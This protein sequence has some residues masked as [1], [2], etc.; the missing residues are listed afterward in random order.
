MKLALKLTVAVMLV[1]AILLLIHG[2]LVVEREVELFEED[3]ERHAKIVGNAILAMAPEFLQQGG[4][5]K[6]GDIIE[7]VN[8]VE[9][10]LHIRLVDIREASRDFLKL[11]ISE[12]DLSKMRDGHRVMNRAS[13]EDDHEYLYAYFPIGIENFDHYAIEIAESLVPMQQYIRNTILRKIVLFIAVVIMGSFLV[14]WLGA[15]M[16]GV[17]V[18]NMVQSTIRVS[19]GDF[20][21]AVIIKN[22][23]DELSKLA[24]GLN[25]MITHLRISRERLNEE[26]SQKMK[27]L[28][29]LHHAERLA[30][31]G[32]LASGLAHELGTPLNVVS[33]RAKM[34]SSGQLNSE[35][36]S[37]CARI[38]DDQSE[39]MTKI[40]RQL[41]DFARQQSP[42][43]EP[44][45][46]SK[47]VGK[48]LSLLGPLASN[49]KIEFKLI[50]PKH[51][52]VINIDPGQIQQVLTNL[53]MN[54]IHAMP[55]GGEIK[56]DIKEAKTQ[57]PADL[58]NQVDNYACV[59]IIDNG[60]GIPAEILSQ[61]FTPF[62]STKDV[63][64]GTGLG[65]SI[66]HGIVREHKGW[67][68]VSSEE[69]KGSIFSVY[70]PLED[71]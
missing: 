40:I 22:K 1:I 13:S 28:E 9:P 2:F 55:D 24:A 34:V 38:I 12:S 66:S 52:L 15:K 46:I 32:K 36:I 3:M 54:A 64:K 65:L 43:K 10:F 59:E 8:A 6:L 45:V 68:A 19:D 50:R 47:L 51:Q 26:T 69:G 58:G 4:E 5:E 53:T 60:V 63:G 23:N 37:E 70:L 29:Q 44:V 61:I 48:V 35:E 33:G 16:V 49:K 14:L 20:S 62:F 21:G 25:D 7:N 71:K 11:H 67:I 17:P 39:R 56:V 41:L 42:Q 57:P 27:A 30:T 18:K 31:V